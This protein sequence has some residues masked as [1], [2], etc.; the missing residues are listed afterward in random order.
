M[1]EE[2]G[3]AE[4][5]L[6]QAL[7]NPPDPYCCLNSSRFG[8]VVDNPSL[9]IYYGE[10]GLRNGCIPTV[11]IYAPLS[12]SYLLRGEIEKSKWFVERISK[13]PYG[14]QPIIWR[15]LEL[16][17][18]APL[19]KPKFD[20]SREEEVQIEQQAQHILKRFQSREDK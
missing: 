5:M 8:M 11:E 1:Q 12:M 16:V 13:D 14:F 18:D 10:L 3:K 17:H 2:Y 6:E 9:S 15:V 19:Q 7:Q 20:H 4:Y